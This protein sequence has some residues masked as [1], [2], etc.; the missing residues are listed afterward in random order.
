MSRSTDHNYDF[1]R[2]TLDV[3]REEIEDGIDR[4]EGRGRF[5]LQI[6]WRGKVLAY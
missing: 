6:F 3:S 1:S 4:E 2:I 5:E